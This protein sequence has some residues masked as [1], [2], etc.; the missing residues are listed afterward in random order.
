M[1]PNRLKMWHT[2]LYVKYIQENT[3]SIQFDFTYKFS[4]L[5]VFNPISERA[6]YK[7]HL[8]SVNLIIKNDQL[9]FILQKLFK[10][11]KM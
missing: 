10:N 4:G 8:G 5:S 3:F 9:V 11:I 6:N 2:L 1:V 7:R